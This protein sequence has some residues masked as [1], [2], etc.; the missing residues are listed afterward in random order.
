MQT[1]APITDHFMPNVLRLHIIPSLIYVFII[2]LSAPGCVKDYSF[3][4][5][6]IKDTVITEDPVPPSGFTLPFC[7]ACAGK[8]SVLLSK[9]SFKTD[10]TLICGTVT[11][12]V[13]SPDRT[14]F[15]FFG[16]SA[17]SADTGLIMTVYLNGVVLDRDRSGIT[18]E[19][20]IFQYYE[21]GK[22]DIL[23]SRPLPGFSLDITRYDHQTGI[24]SG[25]YG[26][27][28]AR[29]NGAVILIKSGKFQVKFQ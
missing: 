1:M 2:L 12:A 19:R 23:L 17:C 8:D 18:T 7:T 29:Q 9:W 6:T 13:I 25:T 14:A 21:R 20:V 26:G 4:G 5:D 16:P 28:A 11:N 3:E 10:S 15:T 24:A 27:Y 22:P